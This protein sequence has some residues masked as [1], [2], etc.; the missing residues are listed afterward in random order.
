MLDFQKLIPQ[1]SALAVD[2]GSD[3]DADGEI[4]SLA[5]AT[6]AEV[7][8]H[9]E[10]FEEVLK[11]N[12]GNT[13]WPISIPLEP[14]G[15][16]QNIDTCKNAHSV[17][18]CDGSQ[19]MPTQHE[20]ASCFLINIGA[21]VLHYGAP[22]RAILS[23]Y[24]FLFHKQDEIYPL[25]NKRRVHIDE[26]L[27]SFE[28]GLKE[29]SQA[30]VLAEAEKDAGNKVLTLVDG[31]LIP[32]GVDR[33]A[34]RLQQ[35]LLERYAMELDAFNA[36]E[37]PVLGYISHSR[38]S[39]LIN[40]LRV[41]RCPYPESKCQIH[42]ASINEDEFP[43]SDIWPLSDRQL[44]RRLLPK[45]ARSNFFLSGSRSSLALEQRN[46]IC[47]AYMNAGQESARIEVPAWLFEDKELLEFALSSLLLQV[48]K[49]EGYP[50]SL[51]E[52][53][54]L[55]V[56]RQQDRS[57][58]FQLLGEKLMNARQTRVAVS[59]KETRKRRGIV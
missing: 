30:R 4:L 42:C 19:V 41:W 46:R 58:F 35:D 53:H 23:T 40:A 31:S 36:A 54:N 26:T 5:Q 10:R 38:S 16:F 59:P 6:F 29:L 2:S 48:K 51:S 55:A 25:I 28:R 22:S 3:N 33:N 8:E 27:V 44:F 50:I 57:R 37:I 39:D 21:V 17:V 18:A 9:A 47:F 56:V 12:G 45:S 43:C 7:T 14:V 24:P 11:E 1:I 20:V 13:F 34:D 49:G 32:F 52:A 15:L